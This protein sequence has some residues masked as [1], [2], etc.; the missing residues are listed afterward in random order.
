M[1]GLSGWAKLCPVLFGAIVVLAL[2][3]GRQEKPRQLSS[4]IAADATPEEV[5]RLYQSFLDQDRFDQVKLLSTE[6]E[7]ARLEEIRKIVIEEHQDSTRLNSVFLSLS[8]EVRKETASCQCR[9]RDQYETY[10]TSFS[11]VRKEGRWL[12]DAP[13]EEE[14]LFE[15]E[16]VKPGLDRFF[17]QSKK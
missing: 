7:Q 16:E 12:V 4:P 2:F 17:E 1:K 13:D 8:C 10:N 11:L 15:E 9:I 5:V 14:V 3:S 6:R